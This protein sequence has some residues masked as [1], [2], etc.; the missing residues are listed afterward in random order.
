MIAVDISQPFLEFIAENADKDGLRNVSVVQGEDKTSN[1]PDGSVD[2]VFHSDTYHHFE[3]PEDM[4]RDLA[5]V[6]VEGGEMYVLDFERIEGVTSQRLLD[7]VR[8]GK[9]VVTR[10]IEASGFT[11][12]EELEVPGLKENYLLRFRKE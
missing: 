6:L 3:Y 8:A 7:H 2:I 10:E 9:D 11:L 1:L 4:I 5:R 12:V